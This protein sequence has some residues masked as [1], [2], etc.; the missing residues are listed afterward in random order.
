MSI[1]L[2]RLK[3]LSLSF[4]A[5]LLVTLWLVP[6][7]LSSSWLAQQVSTTLSHTL[8]RSVS[9]AGLQFSILPR[10]GVVIE[11]VS[12]TWTEESPAF[13]VKKVELSLHWID[14]IGF[15]ITLTDIVIDE[16]ILP[17][18]SLERLG[19]GEDVAEVQK[20]TEQLDDEANSGTLPVAIGHLLLN[21][22]VISRIDQPDLGPYHLDALMSGPIQPERIRLWQEGDALILSAKGSQDETVQVSLI[23]ESWSVPLMASLM[24]DHLDIKAVWNGENITLNSADLNMLD[25]QLALS[26]V[27]DVFDHPKIALDLMLKGL[28]LEK[29]NA[30]IDQVVP[31]LSG[32]AGFEGRILAEADDWSGV[33]D[34]LRLVGL[35]GGQSLNLDRVWLEEQGLVLHTDNQNKP[36]LI[37]TLQADIDAGIYDAV[38]KT[39][40]IHALDA[41]TVSASNTKIS[42]NNGVNVAGQFQL[43]PTILNRIVPLLTGQA[44]LDG[45]ASAK[46]SFK[47]DQPGDAAPL[48][49]QS[50]IKGTVNQVSLDPAASEAL[51]TQ[52]AGPL[53]VETLTV[54]ANVKPDVVHIDPLI[55][56]MIVAQLHPVREKTTAAPA[57]ISIPELT[58]SGLLTPE[59]LTQSILD[60]K[61][62]EGTLQLDSNLNWRNALKADANL[63]MDH[64]NLAPLNALLATEAL[65]GLVSM[66]GTGNWQGDAELWQQGL[67]WNGSFDLTGL[68]IPSELVAKA[69]EK[70][71][72]KPEKTGESLVLEK[73]SMDSQFANAH[74]TLEQ[75]V[76]HGLDGNISGQV[77]GDWT[78]ER[79]WVI[80]GDWKVQGIRLEPLFRFLNQDVVTG[81]LYYTGSGGW[82]DNNPL[83]H[84]DVLIKG[85][86]LQKA[87]LQKAATDFTGQGDSKGQTLFDTL[88]L[89]LDMAKGNLAL[90][91]MKLDSKSLE[92]TGDIK[93][94]QMNK[95]NGRLEVGVKGASALLGIPVKV[96]GT[97]DSP[98]V[99]PTDE[100]LAGGLIGSVLLGP[101]VGTALGMKLGQGLRS[102]G[103]A[104]SSEESSNNEAEKAAPEILE[105]EIIAAETGINVPDIVPYPTANPWKIIKKQ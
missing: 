75:V 73:I 70:K 46:G 74:A 51:N 82:S 71:T 23:A 62:F 52:L 32:E 57:T 72:D 39:A 84:G 19:S 98:F 86:A 9:I 105:N 38:L 43:M 5:L 55:I 26:G 13:E 65:K 61:L 77:V 11:D 41:T 14:L 36:T 24:V 102:I 79:D 60:L 18:E 89:Q 8:Q 64:L 99:R 67:D 93:L 34:R 6:L 78:V 48:T 3:L 56:K 97:V 95:L 22:L 20:E 66:R 21:R 49:W 100:V 87:D 68:E 12:V 53:T 104:F 44:G 33:G 4:I 76:I 47:V 28:D 50:Q 30:L 63:T 101:G 92:V 16:L 59:S 96:S 91:K 25:A 45:V 80:N 1:Q 103:K 58:F 69:P 40:S 17:L 85:G 7:L 10:P 90:K 81:K 2:S 94:K 83:A 31:G 88:A 35:L 54:S 29:V 37:N 15:P 42:W 27:V